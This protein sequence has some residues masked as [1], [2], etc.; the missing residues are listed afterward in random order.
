MN[1]LLADPWVSQQID[2]ALAPYKGGI[3]D[4]E[5]DWMREQLAEVLAS[6]EH[7]ALLLRRAHPRE[8]EQSGE[9]GYEP[10]ADSVRHRDVVG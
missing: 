5:L 8:V 9:V 1:V 3:S 6:D 7:A 4:A 10:I 2:A